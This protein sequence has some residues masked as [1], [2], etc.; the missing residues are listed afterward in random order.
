[1]NTYA[2]NEYLQPPAIMK[3]IHWTGLTMLACGAPILAAPKEEFP[4]SMN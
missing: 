4:H 3:I 1:M 2:P